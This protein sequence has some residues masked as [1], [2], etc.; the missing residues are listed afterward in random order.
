MSVPMTT[1]LT[2]LRNSA[3]SSR[4]V[5][6]TLYRQLIGSLIYLVHTRPD[7]CYTM[8]ALSQFTPDPKH[9]HWKDAK[10]VLRYVRGTITYGLRYTS[11]NRV[12]LAGYA[13]SNWV[14]SVVDQKV[15]LVIG[16]VWDLLV[17]EI[18]LRLQKNKPTQSHKT[19]LSKISFF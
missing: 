3:T 10:H 1:N 18:V 8:N 2:K 19:K 4:S 16:F 7:I 5:D 9:I 15:P 11:S 17:P 6:S 14:G 12:L 13:N